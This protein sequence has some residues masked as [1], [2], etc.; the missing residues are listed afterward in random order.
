MGQDKAEVPVAGRTMAAWTVDA[1]AGAC[2]AVVA[3]GRAGELAGV[4]CLPDPGDHYRGPLAGLIAGLRH[5]GRGVVVLLAVDQPWARA[6]TL[7]RLAARVGDLPVLPVDGGIRQTTCAAYPTDVLSVAEEELAGGGSL[8]SLL[9]RTAFD[10]VVEAEW[11]GW[12]EDGRSWF[13][14]DS[15]GGIDEGIR[16]FGTPAG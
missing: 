2:D 14:A 15:P 16:R 9:D 6:A 12:G 11:V 8:Q 4:P 13:S 10:P 5:V 1:L 3:V 7:R